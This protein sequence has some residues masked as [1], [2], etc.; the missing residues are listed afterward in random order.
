[1]LLL[2]KK[3]KKENKPKNKK[4]KAPYRDDDHN[5]DDALTDTEFFEIMEDD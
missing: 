4:R 1:M 5:F 3:N 2:K